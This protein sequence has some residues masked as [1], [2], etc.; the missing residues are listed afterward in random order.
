MTHFHGP[1]VIY[2]AYI[3]ISHKGVRWDRGTSLPI[4]GSFVWQISGD[5]I[6]F[7]S[8]WSLMSKWVAANA[9]HQS[10]RWA[11]RR[12]VLL[13]HPRRPTWHDDLYWAF[14]HWCEMYSFWL[15]N[16][17]KVTSLYVMC[18]ACFSI[19]EGSFLLLEWQ[20]ICL[21]LFTLMMYIAWQ[22]LIPINTL[23]TCN[24]VHKVAPFRLPKSMEATSSWMREP[25]SP[26]AEEW[27]AWI[28]FLCAG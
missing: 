10:L 1:H 19:P 5:F 4:P 9:M 28:I 2:R 20:I 11:M 25:M 18:N 15:L 3:G 6:P 17:V 16:S 26:W 23:Y 21:H 8:P 14:H 7:R 24:Q 22:V 12:N 13:H 27:C